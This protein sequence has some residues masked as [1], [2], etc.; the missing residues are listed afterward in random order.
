MATASDTNTITNLG[1]L[2][3]LTQSTTKTAKSSNEEVTKNE[4]LQL[5]VTQLKYQDPMDPMK[6]EDFAVN[7]A[8]FSQL[9]QLIAIKDGLA[10]GSDLGSL[11]SYLG[12]EVT[13]QTSVAHVA[14]G[15]GGSAV[16]SLPSD[17]STARLELV[18]SQG[19][20]VK[21]IE[22]GAQAAGRHSVALN[23]LTD[24]D[25]GYYQLKISGSTTTGEEISADVYSAGV[26]TGVIPGANPTLI[27]GGLEVSPSD[28][29][30]VNMSSQG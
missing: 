7:L 13:L 1:A 10:G 26:V 18:D 11:T 28:V 23:N 4:F 16:F 30:E 2:N 6:N 22:L 21:T 19:R 5:L 29:R 12:H 3:P 15:D 24:V 8:Q 9:E 25:N 27:I 20:T 17:A 14:N